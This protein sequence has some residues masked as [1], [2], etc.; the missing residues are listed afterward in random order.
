MCLP[1]TCITS[2][3]QLLDTHS[4]WLSFLYK[5]VCYYLFSFPK[6]TYSNGVLDMGFRTY[7]LDI[8]IMY[9]VILELSTVTLNFNRNQHAEIKLHNLRL[10]HD[11]AY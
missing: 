9:H 2:S 4:L 8:E 10:C 7:L 3:R 1:L 11:I 6:F 5:K